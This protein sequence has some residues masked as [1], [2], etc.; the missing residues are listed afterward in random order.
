MSKAVSIP[1]TLKK[2]LDDAQLLAELD[3]YLK[4][5][6]RYQKKL[7]ADR[8]LGPLSTPRKVSL[9]DEIKEILGKR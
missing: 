9:V 3:G 8:K 1:K 6:K 4:E 2:E 5:I 7:E